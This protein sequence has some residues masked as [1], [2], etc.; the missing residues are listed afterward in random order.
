MAVIAV[1]AFVFSFGNVWSLALRLGIPRPI[2]PLIAPMVDL[3][4][5][6]LLVG[7]R[8]LSLRGVPSSELR[9]ATRLMHLSGLLTLGLNIA[10]PLLAGRY[11]RATLDAVAPVLLLGWSAVGPG[12]LRHMH[13]PFPA[14]APTPVVTGDREPAVVPN[15]VPPTL[16]EN[17][18]PVP[19]PLLVAARRI[20]TAHETEHGT[21]ITPDRLT[22]RLGI[23]PALAATL[24]AHV[25]S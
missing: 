9:S 10:E 18:S 19:E 24:H 20:A 11:G 14:A 25:T 7:L 21:P 4:V 1:L 15:P 12:L 3:S 16:A 6:G 13:T 23:A 17:S 8:H 2:A 5:I 22:M